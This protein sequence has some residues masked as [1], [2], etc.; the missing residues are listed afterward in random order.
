LRGALPPLLY[1]FSFW[2]FAQLR[3]KHWNNF[4]LLLDTTLW[5]IRN[6]GH[7]NCNYVCGEHH[8]VGALTLGK[9]LYG[10]FCSL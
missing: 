7:T 4:N 3:A 1:T 8:A 10:S 5:G 6:A 2:I 9:K